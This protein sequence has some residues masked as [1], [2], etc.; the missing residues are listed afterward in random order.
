MFHQ[1]FKNLS[2]RKCARVSSQDIFD[3]TS[4]NHLL[5]KKFLPH[6]LL[7]LELYIFID[8]CGIC[9]LQVTCINGICIKNI[10]TYPQNNFILKH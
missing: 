2:L 6:S 3:L 7:N 8:I 10:A 1:L 5:K 4:H 9:L